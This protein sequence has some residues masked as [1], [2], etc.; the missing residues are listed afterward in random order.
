MGQLGGITGAEFMHGA[1]AMDLHGDDSE[2]ELIGDLLVEETGD[3]Q[4]HDLAF[5]GS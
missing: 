2:V 4:V 5:A 3:D 1:A